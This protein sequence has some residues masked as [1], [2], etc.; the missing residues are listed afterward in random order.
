MPS[1]R[2]SSLAA[3]S[4]QRRSAG[5]VARGVD[6]GAVVAERDHDRA[7]A[8]R[9]Q[10]LDVPVD[11]GARDV[12]GEHAGT[13]GGERRERPE[14]GA[15]AD[16]RDGAATQRAPLRMLGDRGH[17][18][19]ERA[20]HHA[21]PRPVLELGTQRCAAQRA[22]AVGDHQ[23]LRRARGA[24]DRARAQAHRRIGLAGRGERQVLASGAEDHPGGHGLKAGGGDGPRRVAGARRGGGQLRQRLDVIRPP[25]PQLRDPV[26]KG[27]VGRASGVGEDRAA[28]RARAAA[29]V[30]GGEEDPGPTGRAW[31]GQAEARMVPGPWS[32]QTWFCV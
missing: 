14:L 30:D 3:S 7:R 2:R 23:V 28:G 27:A 22:A 24:A 13:P 29:R 5:Q 26:A 15:G 21:A 6:A 4:S 25:S 18:L 31:I 32:R 11:L 20:L 12:Y 17:R 19:R 8:C 9:G 1:T 10:P 16:Q